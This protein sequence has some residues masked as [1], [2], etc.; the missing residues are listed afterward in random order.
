[1][2]L[3]RKCDVTGGTWWQDWNGQNDGDGIRLSK[4]LMEDDGELAIAAI[5]QSMSTIRI[6]GYCNVKLLYSKNM[7]YSF[8]CRALS[9]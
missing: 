1:M 4:E 8:T 2:G 9:D 3:I 7:V 5:Y 6:K